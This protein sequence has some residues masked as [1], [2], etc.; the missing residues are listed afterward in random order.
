MRDSGRKTG[1]AERYKK[2]K[3]RFLHFIFMDNLFYIISEYA[4][5]LQSDLNHIA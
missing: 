3:R 4:Y 1:K 2:I 5:T